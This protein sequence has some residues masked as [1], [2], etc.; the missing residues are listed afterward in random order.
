MIVACIFD[1]ERSVTVILNYYC[2][3]ICRGIDHKSVSVSR[4]LCDGVCVFTHVI[5][6]VL[7]LRIVNITLCIVGRSPCFFTVCYGEGEFIIF[8]KIT[9][10]DGYSSLER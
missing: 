6:G 8:C 10:I 3:G 9:A 1:T 4:G 7:D 5:N 2:Y